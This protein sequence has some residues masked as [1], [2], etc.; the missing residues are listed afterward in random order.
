M[1][2]TLKTGYRFF[3]VS[4]YLNRPVA[5]LGL[6]MTDTLHGLAIAQ[7]SVDATDLYIEKSKLYE[8][9]IH[10]SCCELAAKQ[11]ISDYLLPSAFAG[12]QSAVVEA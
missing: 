10:Y 2:P 4:L 8:N 7:N 1:N 9:C 12:Y 5:V 3:F 6:G 11:Q